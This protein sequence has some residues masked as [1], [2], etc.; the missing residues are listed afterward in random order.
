MTESYTFHCICNCAEWLLTSSVRPSWIP[1]ISET[2][3]LHVQIRSPAQDVPPS[4][5]GD[6]R[7]VCV[8]KQYGRVDLYNYCGV[9]YTEYRITTTA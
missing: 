1:Q 3:V 8:Q 4:S 6:H 7:D 9:Y 5:K 2:R